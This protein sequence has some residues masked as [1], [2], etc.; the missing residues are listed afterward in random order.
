MTFSSV[1]EAPYAVAVPPTPL[2]DLVVAHRRP[3]LA[4]DLGLDPEWLDEEGFRQ[5]LAGQAPL[6]GAEPRASVYAGHQFGTFVPQLGDGRAHLLGGCKGPD[7]RRWELQ[8]KGAGKTPY[9]RFADGRAVLRS[10]L[11]EYVASEALHA[12]GVP[13]TRALALGVSREPVQRETRER[14]AIVLRVAPSFL[15]FG[16][17]E[18]WAYRDQPERVRRLAEQAIATHFPEHENDAVGWLRS[19]L[20]RTA[21]LMAQWQTLGFCHGVMNT[22]N[23]S[24][25]GLTLDYGPYGFLDAFDPHHICNHSDHSGRYAWDQQPAVGQ[26]NA[27][28]LLEACLGLLA[29][30]TEAAIEIAQ[31]LLG[32]YAGHY[33]AAARR[34]WQAKF[35][36]RETHPGDEALMQAFLALLQRGRHDF[37]LCFRHLPRPA[38]LDDLILDREAL[39]AWQQRY[40]QRLQQE[41]GA[42]P[43]RTAAMDAVNPLY[44][45]RNHLLQ[46]A[47]TAAEQDDFAPLARLVGVL[48]RPYTEQPGAE[49]LAALPPDWAAAISVSCS[50]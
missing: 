20:Q 48:D 32:D 22:D 47:I 35:G 49:D 31:D 36:L 33:A 29:P 21:E 10:S 30:E 14:A 45:P 16:H 15:R 34:R 39:H 27:A 1:L 7:G 12:L 23:M 9:S 25:L 37:S 3:A 8:L 26:W 46:L 42:S 4:L 40:A 5:V 17:F 2:P 18:Y 19:V 44:I 28:R 24:L 6:P 41:G 38:L 11:R 13:T 43:E 50:S